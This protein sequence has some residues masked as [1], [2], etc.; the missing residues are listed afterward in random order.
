MR[1]RFEPALRFAA[2]L[3]LA[4]GVAPPCSG[5]QGSPASRSPRPDSTSTQ[6][7]LQRT[8]ERELLFKQMQD[9]MK[10]GPSDAQP[11]RQLALTQISEDF[12]R[13]QVVNNALAKTLATGGELDLKQ[14]A[15]SASEIRKRAGRLKENLLLPEPAEGRPRSSTGVEPGQLKAAL[16]EL[17]RLVVSFVHNPGFRSVKV[18]DAEWSARAR[19][20][21]EGII[22]LS[23]RVKKSSEQLH[24]AAQKS[25]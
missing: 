8:L 19:S 10:G 1:F 20:D 6:R 4:A 2:A 3:A 17:D 7:E 18:V 21:L 5:Q 11:V 22:E 15:Q 25:R 23:G 9:A 12:L 24:K 14:V 16:A 13:I